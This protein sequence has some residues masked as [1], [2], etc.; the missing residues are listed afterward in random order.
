MIELTL[1]RARDVTLAARVN[2]MVHQGFVFR[3]S[4]KTLSFVNQGL[5]LSSFRRQMRLKIRAGAQKSSVTRP[6]GA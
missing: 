1:A 4:V 3:I 6:Q 5:K 2:D